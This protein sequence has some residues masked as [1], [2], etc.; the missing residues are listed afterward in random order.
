VPIGLKHFFLAYALVWGLFVAY[1]VSLAVRQKRLW[2]EM[3][4]LKSALARK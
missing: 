3:E 2:E 1:L 4:A